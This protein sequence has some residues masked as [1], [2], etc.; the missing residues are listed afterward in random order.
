MTVF[1]TFRFLPLAFI[2]EAVSKSLGCWVECQP[3]KGQLTGGEVRRTGWNTASQFFEENRD[4]ERAS[5]VVRR[6]TFRIVWHGEYC[7]LYDS[8]EVSHTLQMIQ[9]YSRKTVENLFRVLRRKCGPWI[10]QALVVHAFEAPHVLLSH[11]IPNHVPRIQVC[12]FPH[13]IARGAIVQ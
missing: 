1:R 2:A 13:G 8:G 11:A 5:I 7:V 3:Q 12:T 4:D 10:P 6:I 9:L